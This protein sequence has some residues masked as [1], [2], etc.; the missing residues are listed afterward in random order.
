MAST[1]GGPQYSLGSRWWDDLSSTVDPLAPDAD[2]PG[3]GAYDYEMPFGN[4]LKPTY[5][6][7]IAE[8]C[9]ELVF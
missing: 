1:S 2:V 4:L 5:N 6:V 3:P 9:R 8:Q 7:A